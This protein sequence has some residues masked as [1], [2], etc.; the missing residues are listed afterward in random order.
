MVSNSKVL[1][2]MHIEEFVNSQ[3]YIRGV[4]LVHRA[5]WLKT[6][7]QHVRPHPYALLQ[8][9]SLMP[10]F[11]APSLRSLL[12]LDLCTYSRRYRVPRP[13]QALSGRRIPNCTV[14]I[15]LESPWCPRLGADERRPRSSLLSLE[16][17]LV[18]TRRCKTVTRCDHLVMVCDVANR[19]EDH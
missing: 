6:T 3:Q 11:A 12:L 10:H 19:G 4:A 18:E 13:T 2:S 5:S 14:R 17:I 9:V 7:I 15:D 16:S 8:Q 1:C